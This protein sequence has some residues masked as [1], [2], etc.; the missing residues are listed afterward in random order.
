[1]SSIEKNDYEKRLSYKLGGYSFTGFIIGLSLFII[2][3]LSIRVFGPTNFI[4]LGFIGI[5]IIIFL[6]GVIAEILTFIVAITE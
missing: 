1:M 5:G 6:I 3:I 2:G 4:P